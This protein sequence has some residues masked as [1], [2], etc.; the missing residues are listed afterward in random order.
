MQL[1]VINRTVGTPPKKKAAAQTHQG[2]G[3]GLANV[4]Q[5]LQA[6]F[7]SRADCRFGPIAGGYEVSLAMPVEDDD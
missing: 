3:L 2:I 5:R 7:G 4:C 6:H 1:D